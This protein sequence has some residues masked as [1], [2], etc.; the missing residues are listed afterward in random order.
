[1]VRKIGD[2]ARCPEC[3]NYFT[4]ETSRQLTCS[5][6][7]SLL[8]KR[9]KAS[10][11]HKEN[12]KHIRLWARVWRKKN[13]ERIRAYD[14]EWHRGRTKRVSRFEEAVEEDMKKIKGRK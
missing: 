4:I 14:R 8:R 3:K 7:C 11:W 6:E 10:R 2:E 1:M 5:E 12:R 13:R 9:K